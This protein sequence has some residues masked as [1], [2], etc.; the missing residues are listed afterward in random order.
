MDR[1]IPGNAPPEEER[2]LLITADMLVP[3]RPK[4]PRTPFEKDMSYFPLLITL[5]IIANIAVF[6]WE[7]AT[8]ALVGQESVIAA[9]ALSRD[10]VLAGEWWRLLSAAFLH[11]GFDHIL[12]NTI[13]MYILGMAT[14]HAFGLAKTA[15]IYTGAALSGSLLS[16]AMSPG[17]AVGASGAIFGLMGALAVVFFRRRTD[18]YLRDRGIGTFV[19]ALAVLQIALGFS[20][21]VIDNWAHLGGCLGGALCALV[22]RPALGEESRVFSAA[23]KA[24]VTAAVTLTV[25]FYLL[26]AG[27]LAA[28]EAAV[29]LYLGDRPAAIFAAGRAIDRNPDNAY[30]YYLRGSLLLD[31]GHSDAALTDLTVYVARSPGSHRALYAVGHAYHER[32]RYP[33]AIDY[34]TRAIALAPRNVDY[35]NSRGYAYI[36]VGNL[37]AARAD[38]AAAVGINAGYAPGW[39][40]LGLVYAYEGDY[41]KA[42]E[43]LQRAVSLDSSQAPLKKLVAG[44]EAELR[45]R[46]ADAIGHYTAFVGAVTQERANWLA[47]VRFAENRVRVLRSLAK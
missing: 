8:G 32:E 38:F 37:A 47:E 29:W 4:D 19:G 9:G 24:L 16:L 42:V 35:L 21:P 28:V 10:M 26:T 11:G 18:F 20:D 5:L 30:L 3:A 33:E 14:E 17:P 15:V 41:G 46:R 27:Y 22:L 25:G 31:A 6:M 34:Y 39:G 13:F 12:A 40:N 36:F 1:E 7:I 23:R 2:P 44:L 45:G 43:L